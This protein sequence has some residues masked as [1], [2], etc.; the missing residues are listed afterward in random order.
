MLQRKWSTDIGS[1]LHIL[2]RRYEMELTASQIRYLL[3][4]YMIHKNGTVRSADI[5]ENLTVTRPSV[6][7]MIMQLSGMGLLKQEKYS[8]VSFTEKGRILAEQF[9]NIFS[10]IRAF[11]SKNLHLPFD[12]AEEGALAIMSRLHS[13]KLEAVCMQMK[14]EADG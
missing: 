14:L 8:S 3:A 12:S 2:Y 7:R 1:V 4:V 5:A 6:H 11:L 9:Y 10:Y 13:E